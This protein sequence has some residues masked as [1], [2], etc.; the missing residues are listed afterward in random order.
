MEQNKYYE[1]TSNK[2]KFESEYQFYQRKEE[3]VDFLNET[4]LLSLTRACHAI[5]RVYPIGIES[6]VYLSQNVVIEIV[7]PRDS[8]ES[9]DKM[10]LN[11]ISSSKE[12]LE[13]RAKKLEEKFPGIKFEPAVQIR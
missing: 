6:Q 3:I 9:R 5:S 8:L 7:V 13:E 4:N 1:K 12:D 11:I 2:I 10:Y